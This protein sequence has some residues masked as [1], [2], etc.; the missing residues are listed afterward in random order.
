MQ[1]VFITGANRGLG[2][3][4]VRQYLERGDHVFAAARKFDAVEQYDGKYKGTLT[5]ITLDVNNMD[6]ITAA[7]QTVRQSVNAIDILIN[8]AAINPREPVYRTLG[9][10]EAEALAHEIHINA[11]APLMIAQAFVDLLK[12]GTNPKL[13]NITSQ[14]GSMQLKTGAG[15][16][17]AYSISKAA[18]NMATRLLAGDLASSGVVTMM[19]HP[20]WVQTDMGGGGATLSAPESASSLLKIIDNLTS[21][22]NGRFFNINRQ[23]HMW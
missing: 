2:L 15:G 23:D 5:K 7:A 9:S 21:K 10:L 6:E 20:G 8:N 12:N 17:Y 3:E 19:I 18:L 16:P 1:R 14:Q 11:I 13:I 4:I 22:D